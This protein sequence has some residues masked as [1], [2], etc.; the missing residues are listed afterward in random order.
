[1]NWLDDDLAIRTV[2]DRVAMYRKYFSP[3]EFAD[4]GVAHD[5]IR[6]IED[7]DGDG[8][9]DEA[10]VFADGFNNPAVGIGAGV[11]ARGDDV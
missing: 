8:T 2:D 6:R 3:K 1:M 5:R 9:A 10:T 11:L 7:R 4:F